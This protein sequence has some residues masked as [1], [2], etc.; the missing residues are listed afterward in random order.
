[1]L[2][3]RVA[4]DFPTD[5]GDAPS[6][7]GKTISQ[8]RLKEL[9]RYE[10][11]TGHFFWRVAKAR[12]LRVGDRAGWVKSDGYW[13]N[14]LDSKS[15]LSHL[16]TWLY[17]FGRFSKRQIDHKNRNPSDCRI[18]NL[19]EAAH[20]QNL[21]NSKSR[22]SSD[23]KGAYQDRRDGRWQSAINYN[24]KKIHLG[25]FATAEEG[26]AAYCQAARE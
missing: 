16:L 25:T 9:L 22:G 1:M 12:R 21:A 13:C 8:A 19:R 2:H 4:T 3:Q 11:E 26:H 10:P 15:Y 20:G 17:V 14:S 5:L 24:R 6:P 23:L 7:E 18:E